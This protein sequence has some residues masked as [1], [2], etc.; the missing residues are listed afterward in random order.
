LNRGIIFA[1]AAVGLLL[2]PSTPALAQSKLIAK[3]VSRPAGSVWLAHGLKPDHTYQVQFASSG[4]QKFFGRAIER[5]NFV[6]NKR[7][8]SGSKPMGMSGTTPRTF[9]VRAPVKHLN[10]WILAINAQTLSGGRLTV[11]LVDTGKHK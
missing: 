3:K 1:G 9:T 4:H 8:G 11:K 2:L 6:A 5:Y 7:L 10:D